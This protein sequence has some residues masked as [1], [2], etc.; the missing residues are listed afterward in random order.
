MGWPA[1]TRRDDG[2]PGP[3][4]VG[5]RNGLRCAPLGRSHRV[6]AVA[7]SGRNQGVRLRPAQ[8]SGRWFARRIFRR[9]TASFWAGTPAVARHRFA[10][11][12]RPFPA[13]LGFILQAGSPD[14]SSWSMR[15]TRS[16][17]PRSMTCSGLE[18][19]KAGLGSLSQGPMASRETSFSRAAKRR[20]TSVRRRAVEEL[21]LAP[22]DQ[23]ARARSEKPV[24]RVKVCGKSRTGSRGP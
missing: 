14:S 23:L 8:P 4:E 9:K 16:I 24:M 5:G 7:Q 10:R 18:P 15:H 3:P 17:S 6:Q 19:S 2:C 11:T 20:L 21:G 22:C 12:E 13:C 1:A